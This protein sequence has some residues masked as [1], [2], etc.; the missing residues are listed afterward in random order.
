MK[1]LSLTIQKLWPMS[2]IFY[3]DK[4]SD[5]RTDGHTDRQKSICP[6]SI[7]TGA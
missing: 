3:A 6:Q 5:K 2:M 7:D 1:A 4:Q